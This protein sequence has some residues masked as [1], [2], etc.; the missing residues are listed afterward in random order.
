MARNGQVSDGTATQ[1]LRRMAE[2][3]PDLAARLVLQS[4]PAAAA[5]LP[6]GLSYRLELADLGAWRVEAN[7]GHAEVTETEAGA[8]LDGD[9]FA[10]STDA[11]TLAQ[12]ASGASP[13][14]AM[15]RGRLKLRGKRRK[16][17]ALRR[18]SQ[19]A[20]PR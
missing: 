20:G 7:G 17:L 11:R 13:L 9:A 4:L 5:T 6:R 15:L 10:I 18:L 3:D 12:V 14:P 16:A 8:E 2:E 19:D 1:A